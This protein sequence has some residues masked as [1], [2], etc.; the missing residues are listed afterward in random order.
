MGGSWG[1][2]SL[3]RG[4]EHFSKHTEPAGVLWLRVHG[5]ATMDYGP[6]CGIDRRARGA[7]SRRLHHAV[8]DKQRPGGAAETE[9]GTE[10]AAGPGEFAHRG[11]KERDGNH[12]A[13]SRR[14]TIGI[15]AG[16]ETVVIVSSVAL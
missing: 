6:V 4:N 13:D 9:Q 8:A 14:V 2:L 16:Q 12:H 15:L 10:G 5:H 7:G 1:R 3:R 11:R